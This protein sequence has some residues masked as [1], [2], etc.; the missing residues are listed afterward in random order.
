MMKKPIIALIYDFDGTL[1]PYESYAL[2]SMVTL[3]RTITLAA[4]NRRETRGAHIRTDYPQRDPRLAR[5]TFAAYEE[6]RI[7]VWI[8]ERHD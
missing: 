4:L 3:A 7:R 8:G 2:P 6:G 5:P 1:S